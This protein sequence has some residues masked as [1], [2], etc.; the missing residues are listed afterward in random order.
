MD[1]CTFKK[2]SVN[3]KYASPDLPWDFNI[4]IKTQNGTYFK[5]LIYI[6]E[7]FKD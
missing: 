2:L 4:H 5:Y 3:L 6:Y 7:Y 1:Y